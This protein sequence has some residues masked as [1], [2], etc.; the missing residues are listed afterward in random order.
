[1]RRVLN[2]T[3]MLFKEGERADRVFFVVEGEFKITKK[4]VVVDKLQEDNNA[5]VDTIS[6]ATTGLSSVFPVKR[7]NKN[8]VPTRKMQVLDLIIVTTSGIIGDEDAFIESSDHRYMTSCECVSKEAIVYELKQEDFLREGKKQF[9]WGELVDAIQQKR[10]KF[11][12]RVI[13]KN[14]V[15]KVVDKKMNRQKKEAGGMK[16]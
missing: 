15:Q 6:S 11:A 12:M 14:E 9:N 5:A 16:E 2:R 13:Q 4:I 3:Q 1:M 8:Q 7:S 10:D